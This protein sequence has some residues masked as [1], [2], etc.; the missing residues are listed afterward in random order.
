MVLVVGAAGC[1]NAGDE[2]FGTEEQEA[3]RSCALVRCFA[4]PQCAEGQHIIYTPNDCCGRCV[5]P[6][7]SSPRCAGVLCAAV[8]CGA[9][10]QRVYHPGTCCGVCVPVPPESCGISVCGGDEYCCNESC[11]ICAPLDGGF[12]TEQLC[13][14]PL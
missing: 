10:E 6:N 9:G 2:P 13:G 12:C 11:G 7:Q 14:E 1:A 3:A 8:A 4:A 5:G